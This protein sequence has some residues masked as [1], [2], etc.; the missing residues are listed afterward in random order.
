[1]TSDQWFTDKRN[2]ENLLNKIN[3]DEVI[4]RIFTIKRFLEILDEKKNTLVKP[5]K[6]DDP[7]ENF[8]FSANATDQYGHQIGLESLRDSY[9]GQC[10]SFHDEND[11]MWRIYAANKDGVK[12]KTTVGRLFDEFYS[13][14]T[15]PELKCYIGRVEYLAEE[16]IR[17]ILGDEE[18]VHDYIFDSTGL[19]SVK[20]LLFK[21][22][23][24]EHENEVRLIYTT[25]DDTEKAEEIFKYNID[26]NSLFEE[27]VLDPR[28]DEITY[29]ENMKLIISKGYENGSVPCF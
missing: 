12:V 13:A 17:H 2:K 3:R 11:A 26:P 19:N 8:L 4:Y 16:D 29:Q 14:I 5:K 21:R 24:F 23:A 22:S 6:W 27:I 9:F 7:F 1:M 20:S 10:W 28:C 15:G 18:L 25:H